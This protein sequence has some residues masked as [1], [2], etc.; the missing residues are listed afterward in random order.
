MAPKATAQRLVVSFK[1]TI[2]PS[3]TIRSPSF[4]CAHLLS[5]ALATTLYFAIFP[6]ISSDPRP[7]FTLLPKSS[8]SPREYCS[9]GTASPRRNGRVSPCPQRFPP[10]NQRPH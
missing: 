10:V 7:L 2:V 5:L 9:A 1:L 3:I 8:L 4:T 6:P